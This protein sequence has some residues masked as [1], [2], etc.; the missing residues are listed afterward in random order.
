MPALEAITAQPALPEKQRAALISLL[1]DDD[2]AVYKIVRSKLLAFGPT[3][4]QW[5]RPYTL[6]SGPTLRRH[7]VEIVLHQAR[8][9]SDQSFVEF[10]QR[11]GEALDL[12]EATGLP[13]QTRFPDANPDAYRA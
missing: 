10:C 8:R 3:A 5:L 2:P 9:A 11:N 1:A 13:A 7:A 6:S 12:D 4:S